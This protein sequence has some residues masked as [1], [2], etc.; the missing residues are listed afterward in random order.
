ML[1][2]WYSE[3]IEHPEYFGSDGVHL[4]DSGSKALTGLIT[5]GLN[6]KE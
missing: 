2:D 4:T 3:A 1:I 6:T 5:E